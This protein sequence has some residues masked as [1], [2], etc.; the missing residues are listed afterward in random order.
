MN[1]KYVITIVAILAIAGIIFASWNIAQQRPEIGP[2][3]P[4]IHH[5]ATISFEATVISLDNSTTDATI[6]A[7]I[8]IDKIVSVENPDNL[9]LSEIY[10]GVEANAF[11]PYTTGPAKLRRDI[12]PTCRPGEVFKLGSCVIE[13]CEGPGCTAS[14]PIY[15][16]TIEMED[17][18]IVYHLA[19]YTDEVTETILP[20][21]EVG[22]KFKT[23]IKY[24]KRY[25]EYYLISIGGYEIIS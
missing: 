15:E 14:S 7:L 17:G 8:R 5:P 25:S 23:T 22:S 20:G 4:A 12:P 13:G 6:D 18:Y 24:Y 11:F 16:E 1:K 3:G 10:E 9:N 19:K 21:L 2:I